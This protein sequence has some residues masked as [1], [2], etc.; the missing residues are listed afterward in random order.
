MPGRP[1][2]GTLAPPAALA[3][4]IAPLP[5]LV[6]NIIGFLGGVALLDACR[7]AEPS[8]TGIGRVNAVHQHG[9]LSSVLASSRP[10]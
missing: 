8:T 1:R 9:E 7:G 3:Q 6:L 4:R 5:G 2:T 10:T